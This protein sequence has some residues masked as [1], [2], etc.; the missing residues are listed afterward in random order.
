[1]RINEKIKE[2]REK[3]NIT[4]KE[5]A[6]Y[7]EVTQTYIS[8]LESSERNLTIDLL[9]KIST[10]FVCDIS[11]LVDDDK[12]VKPLVLPFRKKNYTVADLDSISSANKIILNF[13]E[14]IDLLE[15]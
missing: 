15:E 12:T 3:S 10:L 7:L 14:M 2:L 9:M 6:D 13:N 8:K 4:Q 1:M 11:E 5:M